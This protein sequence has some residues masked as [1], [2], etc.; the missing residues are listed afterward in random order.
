MARIRTPGPEWVSAAAV[1]ILALVLAALDILDGAVHRWWAEHAFTNSLVSGLL[2]LLVTVLVADRVIHLR[3]LR[4]RSRA[5][6]AQAAIVLTQAARTVQLLDAALDGSG[7]THAAGDALQSYGTMLLI[8]APM[9]I[10][11]STSRTFLE[12]AQRLAGEMI[13]VLHAQR[14]GTA[15][16]AERKHLDDAVKRLRTAAQPLMAILTPQQRE[17]VSDGS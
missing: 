2:V 9:L 1:T 12:E 17:A 16:D 7:D 6:A 4:D 8:A 10:D 13:R 15:G 3:Q 14:K 5:I 11:A